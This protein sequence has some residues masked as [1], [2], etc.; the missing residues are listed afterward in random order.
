LIPHRIKIAY[1]P[2]HVKALM[3][4]KYLLHTL[5][6]FHDSAIEICNYFT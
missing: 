4:M 5:C 1:E 3:N 2:V 6:L